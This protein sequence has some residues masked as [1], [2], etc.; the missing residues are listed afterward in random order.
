MKPENIHAIADATADAMTLLDSLEN[1]LLKINEE[2]ESS[3]SHHAR[4]LAVMINERLARV[5]D[6]VDVAETQ[7]A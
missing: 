7:T 3:E 1:L 5:F 2:T 4:R 6:L